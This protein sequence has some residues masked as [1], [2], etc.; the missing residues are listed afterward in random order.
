MIYLITNK[1]DNK[2]YIGKTQ[3]TIEQRW[4][5]HC[6]NAEYGVD[7]YLYR[8]IRKHGVENF[9][10]EKIGEG[11]NDEEILLIASNQPA[12][13]MTIGGEGGNTSNSP[14]YQKAMLERRNYKGSNNPNFGKRGTMSPNYGKTRTQQQKNNMVNCEYLKSK[15]RRVVINDVEYD[16]VMAAAKAHNRSQKW[17]R[18]HDELSKK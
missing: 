16:S 1:V 18:I 10:V 2:Q 9:I 8:A 7:T 5:E 3:R 14:N 15:R 17:V 13:N 6:K 4:Y 11:L 12:Y